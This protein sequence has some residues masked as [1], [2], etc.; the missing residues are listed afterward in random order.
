MKVIAIP[1]DLI[2]ITAKMNIQIRLIDGVW[3]ISDLSFLKFVAQ[4]LGVVRQPFFA[5]VL[6]LSSHNPFVMPKDAENLE[7]K[8]G[9][10]PI[11]ALASYTDHAVSVFFE[12][13][14]QNQWYD[15]TL[16]IITGDHIGE[17][18][19]PTP[20]SIYTTLQIPIFFFHPAADFSRKMGSMQQLDIMPSLF[21]YLHID[22]PL[23]SYGKNIFDSTYTL[24]SA[25]YTW[26]IYQLVT[27]S[28]VLQF[29]GENAIGLFD[30]KK[31]LLMQHN[32]ISELPE[33][34]AL[35]EQKLKAIL[36]SYTTRLIK[37]QL[38]LSST[39]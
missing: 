9:P 7:L 4:K 5:G 27:E 34:A 32:L 37:N 16:F 39:F 18:S 36:Q 10:R 15:S 29:D 23:F 12:T 6:T 31:D 2:P 28:Y 33:V 30:I 14:S 17:G 3:G 1:L 13:V 20:C 38:F 8:S 19:F 11:H 25:N 21:A 35:Y 26:G 24:Y 22:E